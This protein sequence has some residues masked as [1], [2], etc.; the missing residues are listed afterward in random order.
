MPTVERTTKASRIIVRY[1]GVGLSMLRNVKT[2]Y[3]KNK[4]LRK[5][6]GLRQVFVTLLNK[7]SVR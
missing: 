6:Q 4:C 5:N 2:D 7:N 1:Q 3:I